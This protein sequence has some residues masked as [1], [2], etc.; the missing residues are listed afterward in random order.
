[1][2]QELEEMRRR[3]MIIHVIFF[4][5]QLLLSI[6]QATFG[7]SSVLIPAGPVVL[8]NQPEGYGNYA[9]Q[10]ISLPAYL[11]D[12]YEVTNQ[13]F[14][15]FVAD[16]GYFRQVYWII[17]GADDS[18][19][20]WRWRQENGIV[21]PKF[22]DLA[23]DPYWKK[24]PY[25]NGANTPVVGVSWF[26]AFAYARW[27]GKRLPTSAEWEKAARGTSDQHGQ[28][29]GVG[30]GV[31][32][33]WGNKFFEGQTP[34]DYKLC[35]WRLRYW[36]YRYPDTDGRAYDVGYPLK[37]WQND[38]FRESAAPV[39]SY[40]PQGD[41]PYGVADMAGNVWEW[42]ATSHP[43]FENSLKIIRGGCWYKSTLDHLKSGYIHAAGP[44]LRAKYLGFRC[45]SPAP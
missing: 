36:A 45:V 28:W 26:E 27:A 2:N 37:V 31:K 5:F 38:G 10:I 40:S 3:S 19:A 41:S 9:P 25:S 18:L 1:M 21:G 13:E 29:Q 34:P 14:A 44:Y 17:S 35:N 20:G 16:S 24:D 39:G 12:R 22:W 42:T 7:Q 33:P 11:I 30:V 23:S 4:C 32:Y 15:Q 8:G 6:S 43:Q